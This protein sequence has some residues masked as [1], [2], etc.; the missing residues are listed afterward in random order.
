MKSNRRGTFLERG[1]SFLKLLAVIASIAILAALTLGGGHRCGSSA[2]RN[3]TTTVHAAIKAGI[4]QYIEKH[5][6]Y[7]TPAHPDATVKISGKD[8]R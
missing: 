5:G 4:E 7:P 2:E 8:M 6:E 1:F 3:R